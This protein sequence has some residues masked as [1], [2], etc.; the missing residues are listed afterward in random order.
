M[1][2]KLILS[3]S[4]AAMLLG[5]CATTQSIQQ[6]KDLSSSGIAYT[7]AVV[8]LLVITTDQVIDFDSAELIKTR[9]GTNPR[10]MVSAKNDGLVGVITELN[11]FRAQTKLLKTYFINLQAL[12]DSPVKDDAGVAVKSLSDSIS[13]L[14]K[15]LEGENGEESLS[16]DQK[17]QI[18]AL[19]GLVANT[20]HTA[21]VKNAL[22]RD[23]E[24][25]GTYLALQENQLG[26][27][28]DILKD[29]FQAENDLF[30][31][32][33]VIAPYE[34]KSKPLPS[35]WSENRKQWVKSQFVN[36]QL[37]T[38]K[39]AAK[40]LGGVWADILQGK[41]DINSLSVLIYD[42]NEFVT[43]IKDLEDA[44]KAADKAS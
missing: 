12:A 39:E 24:V 13:K 4:L 31:N 44:N 10:E 15:A 27:I 14:N 32:K 38:A 30:L 7:D 41:S 6:G 8:N 3:A 36:Q 23:A 43:T 26:N 16:E 17:T 1:R 20:I 33:E 22:K 21:K 18:G 5:G 35:S 11:R 34:D 29:R 2:R 28:T 25:I 19:G 37:N 40:Q 9:R 42:V